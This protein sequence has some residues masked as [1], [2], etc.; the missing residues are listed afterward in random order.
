MAKCNQKDLPVIS[1]SVAGGDG[2]LGQCL[3]LAEV[4]MVHDWRFKSLPPIA[5]APNQQVEANPKG[6]SDSANAAKFLSHVRDA[7]RWGRC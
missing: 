5:Y 6:S 2:W 1:H 7:V 4:P 3:E